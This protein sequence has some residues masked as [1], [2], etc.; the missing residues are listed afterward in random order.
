MKQTKS[1]K[2]LKLPS[3]RKSFSRELSLFGCVLWD[4]GERLEMKHWLGRG[5]KN[6]LFIK[7]PATSLMTAWYDRQ[8]LDNFD[9]VIADKVKNDS[10]FFP[11][12]KKQFNKYWKLLEPYSQTRLI[13]SLAELEKFYKNLLAWWPLMVLIYWI[14]VTEKAKITGPAVTEAMRLREKTEKFSNDSELIFLKFFKK[15]FP[16]YSGLSGFIT[17]AEV[18]SSKKKNFNAKQIAIFSE[19]KRNGLILLN[20]NLY[21]LAEIRKLKFDQPEKN[22]KEIKGQVA[23]SGKIIGKVRLIFAVNDIYKIKAGE[24]LVAPMTTPLFLPAIKKAS[25]MVTDEGGIT[26]HAAIVARE[27]KKP[28]IIGTKIATRL[29]KDGDLVEVDADN[30]IVK[31][32]N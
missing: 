13:A 27:L 6:L 31:I 24:I 5:I 10:M 9:R 8:E 20:G 18:F 4:Q 28:C 16:Q 26:C 22:Q 1:L 14:P 15:Y 7:E 19:R 17:P 11:E 32:L 3:F 12:V 25:A 2:K 23:F 30:G 29:L 21:T